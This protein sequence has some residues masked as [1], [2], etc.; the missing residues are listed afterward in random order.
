[1]IFITI[2][3]TPFPFSRMVDV[4]K[5]VIDLRKDNEEI[6]FQCGNTPCTLEGKNVTARS[7][8]RFFDMQRYIHQARV[9]ICHGGPATIYQVLESGKIP[10]VIARERRY[11]EHVNNHQVY[12]YEFLIKN[13]LVMPY[14]MIAATLYKNNMIKINHD[15]FK[16]TR[17]TLI[18]YLDGLCLVQ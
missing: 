15:I 17:Q 12:F 11:G 9:I 16:G 1:M 7:Y 18:K 2:G 10:Y 14:S 5:N 3:T 8:F 6:V 13:N 4:V